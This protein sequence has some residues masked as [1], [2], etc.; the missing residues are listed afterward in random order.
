MTNAG[1]TPAIK[2]VTKTNANKNR[3]ACSTETKNGFEFCVQHL[4][5]NRSEQLVG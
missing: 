1:Y 5:K 3:T 4:V 2:P